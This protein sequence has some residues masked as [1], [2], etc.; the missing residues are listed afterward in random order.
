M[1]VLKDSISD[2]LSFGDNKK[3]HNS[4]N[5]S[6]G[7]DRHFLFGA[8]ISMQSI[9]NNNK[10]LDI[11]FHLFTDYLDYDYNK[12]I[13][14]FCKNNTN[15]NVT[16]YKISDKFINIFPSAK[17]W[18]YATFFRFIAFDFLAEHCHNLLY[19]DAD[20][21]CKGSIRELL[22][23]EFSDLYYAAVVKDNEFMQGKPAERLNVDGLPGNYFNAGFIYLNLKAWKKNK[24]MQQALSMLASDVEHKKYKCLD[25]D[26]LNILFFKHC[27]FLDDKYDKLYGVDYELDFES[28]NEYQSYIND[29]TRL[30]HYVGIT[31]PWHNWTEYPSESYFYEAYRSSAWSDVPLLDAKGEGQFKA[32]SMHDKKN[33]RSVSSFWYFLKYRIVKTIRKLSANC[34]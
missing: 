31:K 23:L 27:L 30:V 11:S 8:A 15:V 18:S 6:Y 1:D 3:T 17:Q 16:I 28:E 5:I 7:V 19:I 33:G 2:I 32:K 12:R 9:V 25:Q 26:I 10:D 34:S 14:L 29:D 24:F 20:I 4:L 21:I 22:E 13:T